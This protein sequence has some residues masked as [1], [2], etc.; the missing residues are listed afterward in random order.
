MERTEKAA[1]KQKEQEEKTQR[2]F[3]LETEPIKRKNGR[4]LVPRTL[5]MERQRREKKE[6]QKKIEAAQLASDQNLFFGP[7]WE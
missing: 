4:S 5:Q 7:I 6:E 2:A 3:A 1:K